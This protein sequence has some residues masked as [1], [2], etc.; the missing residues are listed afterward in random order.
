MNQ[1]QA[2]TQRILHDPANG[3]YGDC[4]RTAIAMVLGLQPE[5]VPHFCDDNLYDDW[6][7][8]T[9]KW[10][11]ERGLAMVDLPFEHS[12]DLVCDQ[13]RMTA[14]DVPAIVAGRSPRG[15][16]HSVVVHHGVCFDPHPEGGGLEP[17]DDGL[18]WVSFIAGAMEKAA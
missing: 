2:H 14:G 13:L 17:G 6:R 4:Y 10:L 8:V 15:T 12:F 9:D 1:F 5:D 16:M 11:A 18:I 3:R 7:G